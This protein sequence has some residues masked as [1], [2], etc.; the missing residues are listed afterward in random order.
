MEVMEAVGRRVPAAPTLSSQP[1]MPPLGIRVGIGDHL[2]ALV[3]ELAQRQSGRIV[4]ELVLGVGSAVAALAIACTSAVEIEPVRAAL[5]VAVNPPSCLAVSMRLR[6]EA[7]VPPTSPAM[8]ASG[9]T[10]D[11]AL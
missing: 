8:W 3:T 5:A 10:D 4:D 9:D 2:G 11:V 6:T 1:S 7:A